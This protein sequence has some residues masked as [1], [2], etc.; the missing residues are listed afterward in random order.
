[1]LKH[2]CILCDDVIKRGR[3]WLD[4][5]SEACG[6]KQ[7]QVKHIDELLTPMNYC[8]HTKWAEIDF[9]IEKFRIR[10]INVK[11]IK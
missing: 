3:C 11:S 4:E 8:N 7:M 10:N 2:W 9:L 6:E 1:M 5:M